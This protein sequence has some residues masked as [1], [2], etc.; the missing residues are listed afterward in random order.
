MRC[1]R[2]LDSLSVAFVV[3]WLLFVMPHSRSVEAK[4]ARVACAL[5]RGYL[6]PLSG[7]QRHI[8]VAARL[9]AP[10]RTMARAVE[11]H[12]RLDAMTGQR[13]HLLAHAALAA[14]KQ[15]SPAQ[16]SKVMKLN[17]DAGIAKHAFSRR[18]PDAWADVSD[19]SPGFAAGDDPC[20]DGGDAA[21]HT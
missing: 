6:L 15:L 18:V 8:L 10:I 16:F 11:A 12:E 3:T 17:I 14:K 20:C 7:D 9:A 1:C 2:L 5:A 21:A 4:A 13:H 19:D